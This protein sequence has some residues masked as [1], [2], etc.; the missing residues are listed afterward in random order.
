MQKCRRNQVRKLTGLILALAG[1]AVLSAPAVAETQKS[2]KSDKSDNDLAANPGRDA[3]RQIVQNQ[4]VVNWS[5]RQ[6]PSPCERV[7]LAD[8]KTNRSG[9]AV[10]ADAK[11][12]AH[13]LLIPVQTMTGLDGNELL[14]PDTPNYFAEAWRAHDLI[15]KFV[16]HAVPRSAIGLVVNK[17]QAR[18]QDQFHIHI[19]CLRQDAFDSLRASAEHLTDHWSPVSVAGLPYDALRIGSGSLNGTNP[20]DLLA[21]WKPD[22]RNHMGSYTVVVVGMQFNSGPGFIE[23]TGTGPTGELLLDPSCAVAGGGGG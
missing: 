3:L 14:D 9:Y 4:C 11:G 22:A 8:S 1:A 6:D 10:L 16:G 21:S 18:S 5:R 13:Y 12:G 17:A 20:F 19:E 7:F 2:S 15:D 23:L